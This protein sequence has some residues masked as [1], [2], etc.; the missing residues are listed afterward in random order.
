MAED[1][2]EPVT[3]RSG[4]ESSKAPGTTPVERLVAEGVEPKPETIISSE[5]SASA[6]GI[7]PVERLIAQ[8]SV[9]EPETETFVIKPRRGEPGAFLIFAGLFLPSVAILI[10]I[11]SGIC[12]EMFFDPLPT[13]WHKLLVISV[14][15]ANLL[16]IHGLWWGDGAYHWRI[17]L[18]NGLSVVVSI[19]YTIIYLPLMP[20]ALVALLFVGLGLLALTPI[21]SLVAS[22]L[23]LRRLKVLARELSGTNGR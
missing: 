22:A 9:P 11:T 6:V 4:E 8:G 21:L 19:F 12:A 5:D 2:N 1:S 20:I 16:V 10:E 23:C 13:V 14:P 15:L 7:T 18:A 3:F 17:G